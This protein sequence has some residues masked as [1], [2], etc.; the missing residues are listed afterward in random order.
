MIQRVSNQNYTPSFTKH[1]ENP[2]EQFQQKIDKAK[3]YADSFLK[4]AKQSVPVLLGL[5]AVWTAA[6]KYT[7]QIPLKKAFSH[8]MT[9]FFAP[10]LIC[11]SALLSF[12][13]NKK[14]PGKEK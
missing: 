3:P 4:H 1:Q 12:V 14:T 2:K 9:G 5:T 8:N 11:S 6:D 10:V 7:R 13:E